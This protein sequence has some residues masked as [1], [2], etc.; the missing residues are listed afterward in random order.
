MTPQVKQL[1]KILY[2]KA[3]SMPNSD[4]LGILPTHFVGIRSRFKKGLPM[5]IGRDTNSLNQVRI[6]LVEDYEYDELNWLK[7]KEEGYYYNKSSFW[8][9]VGHV[10]ERIRKESFGKDI[11][12]D[13]YWS[14]LYKINFR[15]KKGTTKKLRD[16]QINTCAQLLLAEMDDLEPCISI[17]LTGTDE[18]HSSRKGVGRFFE[19]WEPRGQLKFKNESTGEFT[20]VGESG[21]MHHCIVVPH[22]QGKGEEEII[23][24]ICSLWK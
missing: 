15:E 1:Y 9:V 7:E 4:V 24:K 3:K 17:F 5:F 16:C 19:R 10:L 8:R 13:F 12:Y 14:D 2:E 20:L 21:T 23:Q 6:P 22:P 18:D 11:Y